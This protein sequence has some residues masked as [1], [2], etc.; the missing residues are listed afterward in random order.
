[1]DKLRTSGAYT[2]AAATYHRRFIEYVFPTLI[3]IYLATR[4]LE[5]VVVIQLLV[6]GARRYF[7]PNTVDSTPFWVVAPI[8]PFPLLLQFHAGWSMIAVWRERLESLER[9]RYQNRRRCCW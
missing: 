7:G 4:V 8:A 1:M 9:G 3:G 6:C 2:E 5:T